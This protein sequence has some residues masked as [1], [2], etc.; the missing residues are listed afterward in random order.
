[1]RYIHVAVGV[2]KGPDGK[3][4]LSKRRDDAHQ[5]G[6]WEFPGGKVEVGES[7]QVALRRELKEELA[8]DTVHSL[9]LIQIR[10]HYSDKS[11]LLDVWEVDSY[12]GSP[13]GNEGQPLA[14]VEVDQL[15]AGHDC[16]Y[17]LP[18]A[19]AAIIK[20]LQLPE[21][22]LITGEF[23]G[24]EDF[25]AKLERALQRG[26]RLVQFRPSSST[27][28]LSQAERVE[29][30]KLASS[31]C[32]Q[33]AAKLVVNAATGIP[34]SAGHGLHLPAKQLMDHQSRP[35]TAKQLLG[36][37]CHNQEELQRAAELNAD[38]VLLSPVKSTNS[39]PDASILGWERFQALVQTSNVPV[40][41]LGG[42]KQEDMAKAREAGAQGIAAITAF[43][44]DQR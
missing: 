17:P 27:D 8:I 11:V 9:P 18:A 15:E 32:L 24:R 39:H 3:I 36:A 29:L 19:N 34:P 26:I 21:G 31:L 40:Y 12:R 33:Y 7:V 14:W 2:I 43:W 4:L 6:L 25:L 30:L 1:M 38:Y 20:A 28:R 35:V 22:M 41:A 37:S 44:D 10:H 23:D 13:K 5:G 42:L 16:L